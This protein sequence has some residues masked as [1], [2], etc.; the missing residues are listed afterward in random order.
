[1]PDEELL[2]LA[3]RDTLRKDGNLEKQVRRMLADPKA[4][5]LVDNFAEQWLQIRNLKNLTLDPVL[6]PAFDEGL[7]WA[8]LKE[9]ELFFAAVLT[10]DRSV[11]DFLDAD[12]TF[13]NERLAKHY[14]IQG[15]KGEKFQRVKL[16]GGQRG[17]VLT[18]A[19]ILTVTSNPTRTSPV[20]RGKWI[21]ETILGTPPPPPPPDVPE[22]TEEKAEDATASLRKKMEAHREKPICA[23]CH[24]RMDPLGFGF[25]NF[26]AV[27]AWRTKDGKFTIDPSG[28]LPGGVSFKG[29]AELKKVLKA[30]EAEFRR[31]LAEKMLTYA[32]GRGLEYYDRCAV[33]A[34]STAV[35]QR[36]NRMVSLVLEVVKSDPFQMRRGREP[37]RKGVT[38]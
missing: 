32:L 8:M 19:S 38:K 20:K 22:L 26:D 17:G 13:V 36:D 35:A 12:F 34:I 7:R 21:L 11:L 10:E 18:Q 30:K 15:V 29:P 27:G 6:F 14:G 31:C 23:S 24:Q 1:M 33:D 37:D 28:E 25:E 9:T 5:A 4:Q 3:R 2:T 16:T